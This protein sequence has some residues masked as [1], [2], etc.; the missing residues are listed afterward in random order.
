MPTVSGDATCHAILALAVSVMVEFREKF[1]FFFKVSKAL[2]H[3]MAT[4]QSNLHLSSS[5]SLPLSGPQD[6][7]GGH[8]GEALYPRLAQDDMTDSPFWIVCTFCPTA[9]S[10]ILLLLK[11]RS[12]VI[13]AYQI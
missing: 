3:L 7:D 12:V 11:P 6:Q 1:A 2:L 10:N 4:L 9:Q 13:G 5:T 8:S